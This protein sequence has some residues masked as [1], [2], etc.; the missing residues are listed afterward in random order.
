[1]IQSHADPRSDATAMEN[2]H[3]RPISWTVELGFAPLNPSLQQWSA[4]CAAL[5][6][7]LLAS[8][9][10]STW[11]DGRSIKFFSVHGDHK[12]SDCLI[13]TSKLVLSEKGFGLQLGELKPQL[14]LVVPAAM[15][16]LSLWAFDK[17]IVTF[18]VAFKPEN[19]KD[20]PAF[21][22]DCLCNRDGHLGAF[23]QRPL[24]RC[25]VQLLFSEIDTHPGSFQLTIGSSVQRRKDVLVEVKGMF[26]NECIERGS[27]RR[28]FRNVERVYE[29]MNERALP[30]V[31]QFDRHHDKW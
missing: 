13:T 1:M 12:R 23:F 3:A 2:L 10:E 31:K 6:D 9:R 18:L 27:L 5:R 19:V 25:S 28:V 16:A 24:T 4:T 29:Y 21:V 8:Y 26:L 20:G 22:Q 7:R 11:D 30:F 17:Q 15:D 14:D